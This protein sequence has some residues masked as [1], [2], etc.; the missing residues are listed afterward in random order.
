[1]NAPVVATRPHLPYPKRKRGFPHSRAGGS[2]PKSRR[3][4]PRIGVLGGSFNPAHGGHLDISRQALKRLG[5]DRIW[6]VV[7]PQNPLKKRAGMAEF[8]QRLAGARALARAE[9]RITVTDIEARLGNRYTSDTLARLV[10][11]TPRATFVW[12]M[13]AD[14]LLQI[15]LWHRWTRIFHLVSVAVFARPS[16]SLRAL[17]AKAA[18][19]FARIR[20]KDDDS[21]LLASRRPPAWV[22]VRGRL[23][24]LSATAI[25]SS[26]KKG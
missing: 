22:F 23:N 7:S 17:A 1:M 9:R 12:I 18:R 19:R 15:D 3:S 4:G 21:R 11:R 25:R 16:Y 10:R 14:N 26:T 2:E 8:R 20:L 13:G 6:W 5:V 24:P